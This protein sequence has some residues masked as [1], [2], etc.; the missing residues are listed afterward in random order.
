MWEIINAIYILSGIWIV[1]NYDNPYTQY[2]HIYIACKIAY[3]IYTISYGTTNNSNILKTFM[4]L[5]N[6]LCLLYILENTYKSRL[7]SVLMG[8]IYCINIETTDIYVAYTFNGLIILLA[9]DYKYWPSWIK[10][11]IIICIT[12]KNNLAIGVPL[13]YTMVHNVVKKML[14]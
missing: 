3:H 5:Q 6:G 2:Y 1:N 13:Y 11:F 7:I 12:M 10:V 8:V 14:E 4:F 9:S